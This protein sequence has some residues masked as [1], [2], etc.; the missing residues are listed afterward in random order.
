MAIDN[1]DERGAALVVGKPFLYGTSREFLIRFGLNSLEDLPSME[2]F[3]ALLE[4]D[5]PELPLMPTGGSEPPSG[6]AGLAGAAE[7]GE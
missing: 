3:A 1:R 4:P 2:E 6:D 5:E 7:T